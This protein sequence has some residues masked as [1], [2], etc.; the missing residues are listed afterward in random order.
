MKIMMKPERNLEFQFKNRVLFGAGMLKSLPEQVKKM[1]IKR[2]GM[3]ID[4]NLYDNNAKVLDVVKATQEEVPETV[5][6]LYDQPFEPTY[7]L[8]DEIRSDFIKEG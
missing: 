1:G 4:K 6:Y 3:I 8:L 7:Q 2:V 5:L